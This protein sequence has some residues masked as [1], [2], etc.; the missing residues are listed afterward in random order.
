MNKVHIAMARHPRMAIRPAKDFANTPPP[1]AYAA[2]I[3]PDAV[4]NALVGRYCAGMADHHA[5]AEVRAALLH[6]N[7]AH[8]KPHD[9]TIAWFLRTCTPTDALRLITRAQVPVPAL[10]TF[11]RELGI[12]NPRLIRTLNQ[13]AA[14]EKR[15]GQAQT[16][17][18]KT[19]LS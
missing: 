10:A 14:P 6:G 18:T 16:G 19:P 1:P 15:S 8:T 5:G 2:A 9:P 13:F 7:P 12:E 11:V 4:A 3:N 17:R